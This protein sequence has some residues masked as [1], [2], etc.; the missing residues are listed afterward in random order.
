ML[1]I[2]DDALHG[3]VSSSSHQATGDFGD[4]VATI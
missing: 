4:V 1:T 2:C 3:T